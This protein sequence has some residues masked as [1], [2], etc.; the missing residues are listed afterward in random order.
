MLVSRKWLTNFITI[1]KGFSAEEIA[2][3]VT[4][5]TVEVEGVQSHGQQLAG[6]VIGIVTSVQPHPDA[7]RLR[8]AIVSD[9]STE[10]DV[11]CGGAN[12]QQGMKVAFAKVGATV[13]WH[14]EGELVELKP[15]KIR[16][17]QSEGMICASNEIGIEHLHPCADGDITDLSGLAAEVGTPLA[18]AL[19]MDDTI[20]DIDN[21]SMTHRPDLWG[22]YGLAREL[23]AIFNVP[24]QPYKT[25]AIRAGRKHR[26][27]ASIA[28]TQQCSRYMAVAVDGV[29]V[30]PSPAWLA[31]Q[32]E[33]VGVR[34]INVIVDITNYVML[35]L[36]QPMHA[37]DSKAIAGGTITIAQAEAGQQFT[38][39]DEQEHQ[40]TAD[41]VVIRDD[42][43]ILALAG[44]M[45][46]VDS[47]VSDDTTTVVF[48]SATFDPISIRQTA[49][50]LGIR[51][52]SSARFEK[53]LDPQMAEQ[54]LRRAVELLQQIQ[55]NVQV[56]SKVVD[57]GDWDDTPV[58][59]DVDTAWL[60]R[61]IGGQPLTDQVITDSL[62][63]IGFGVKKSKKK[64]ELTISVP[65]WRATGDI[66]I[67]EDI[68][69]EVARLHG[70]DAIT[71]HLPALPITPPVG[72]NERQL[73]TSIIDQLVGAG[74]CYQVETYSFV[75]EATV[76]LF[77]TTPQQH[78]ALANA[79][80]T[81][82]TLLRTTLVQN[83]VK[84]VADNARY[85]DDIRLCEI[86]RVFLPQPGSY[87]RSTDGG[88]ML[89]DQPKRLTVVVAAADD[90]QPF[91]T[92]KGMAETVLRSLGFDFYFDT[93][94]DVLP[95]WAEPGRSIGVVVDGKA[96][97]VVTE[98]K[99]GIGTAHDID[100]PVGII[101]LDVTALAACLRKPTTYT[102]AA[103]Y[104]AVVRDMAIVVPDSVSWGQVAKTV[105]SAGQ[106]LVEAVELFD[107][108]TGGTIAVDH[109][110]LAFHVT[111][112]ADDR[113]LTAE[114]VTAHEQ[115]IIDALASDCQ[116]SLRQ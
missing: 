84:A 68:V 82:Q 79:I 94:P 50:R 83:L 78:I 23:A 113:T 29:T 24:L 89:P 51:T 48:E 8:V 21:K 91:T 31:S 17:Q 27:Q 97:G 62:K 61:R 3:K 60:N 38:T 16:G 105:R 103:K 66:A 7:D 87:A 93:T 28:A 108:F 92:A 80:A 102:P 74:G 107:I 4:L 59:I 47:G 110:S 96:L 98:L 111:Y 73:E 39:L 42:K 5:Q 13:R 57:V 76:G 46:G 15:I 65:S 63:S 32:L 54:A 20:F 104:P 115:Q 72:N 106:P 44:I 26:L 69:E 70:F 100:W 67:A 90:D 33:A 1:P 37:F 101:D 52:E 10:Y 58:V 11:V 19:G 40:L 116:A 75:N 6:V 85:F 45:G 77:G 30:E 56:V 18:E 88:V 36:G 95:P 86:G 109:K 71:G 2:E 35:E 14:G 99:R 55:S 114:E 34:S 112:Q 81:D 43:K 12:L 49:T 53:G 64:G 41:D 9:G 22:H 25:P